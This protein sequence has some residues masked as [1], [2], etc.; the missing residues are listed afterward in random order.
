MALTKV[1]KDEHSVFVRTN[2]SVYRPHKTKYSY[3]VKSSV[4]D[5]A[6][7][8][9]LG[10]SV[11]VSNISQTPF[12]RVKCGEYVELWHTHG[13]YIGKKSAECWNPG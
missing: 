13:I 4:D 10:D 6:T 9:K 2:G 7:Q 8:L 12:C 3:P 1:R 11:V 5:G